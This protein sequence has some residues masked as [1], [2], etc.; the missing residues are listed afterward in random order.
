MLDYKESNNT[1]SIVY[2][3]PE[4]FSN[5]EYL[6]QN[7]LKKQAIKLSIELQEYLRYDLPDIGIDFVKE[8]KQK[9]EEML[10]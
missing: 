7:L 6:M 9:L 10:G 1:Y 4:G 3:H 2:I 8:L 5:Q